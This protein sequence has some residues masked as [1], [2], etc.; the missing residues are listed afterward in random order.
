[1]P[2]ALEGVRVVDLS[3]VL[4]APTTSMILADLGADV[5]HIEPERGDDSREFGPFVGGHDRNRSGY[6]ISL[7][8]NKKSLVLN[9]KH[10]TGKTVLRELIRISDVVLENFRPDTM[11]KLGFGWEDVRK[12][13]PRAIYCSICGFGHD[14]LPE[15]GSRPAYDMVAQAYSGLMS[16]TGPEGGPPCRV[17]SSVGDIIAGMQGAIGILAALRYREKSGRG[18]CVDI[19]MVDGLFSVLENAVARYVNTREIPGPL[20]GAHPSIA[21]F[22]GYQGK[23]GQWVIAAIGNDKLWAQYCKILGRE[24]LIE[25]PK[26]K[27]NP[28]RC[29]HRKEMNAI[30]EVEMAKKTAR[31]WCDIFEKERIPYSPIN[32]LQQICDDPHIAHRKM[33]VEIDQPIVG[34]MQVC[35]SPLKLSETPGEVYAPAPM[36]GEHSEQVLRELLGYSAEKI[37]QLKADGVINKTV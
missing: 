30:L 13:N 16:I 24:D 10:E 12:I 20:G 9:L 1:M 27:T 34:R 3:H 33:L 8:R 35:A 25:D 7:N 32:T 22:Q 26:F 37:A 15:Y 29:D 36:L 6:F 4:A 18:Q 19:A 2:R 21:P 11:D 5:I 28:L 17:G 23:D 14:S 31:E